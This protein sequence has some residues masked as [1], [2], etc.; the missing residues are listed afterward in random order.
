MRNFLICTLILGLIV[1]C[2][3]ETT[4]DT[5]STGEDA[6]KEDFDFYNSVNSAMGG[7]DK[8]SEQASLD[9]QKLSKNSNSSCLS[10][11]LLITYQEDPIPGFSAYDYYSK[12]IEPFCKGF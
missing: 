1:S 9:I 4:E 6:N 3:T 2:T 5:V 11:E 10:V 7:F 12:L 8:I